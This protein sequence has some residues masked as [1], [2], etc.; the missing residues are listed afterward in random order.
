TPHGGS[1]HY[2][3]ST[4]KGAF[5]SR[6]ERALMNHTE[7]FLFESAFARNTYQR[8]IGTP[9]ALVRCVFNGV[10]AKE[11][12]PLSITEDATGVHYVGEFRNIKGAD[13]L[14]D[15]IARLRSMG[16][17][18][19]LTLAG[20]GEEMPALQAQSERLN[21]KSAVR[22]IGHVPARTGFSKGRV[23]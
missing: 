13:I 2:A 23:L 19:T 14:I 21:L 8:T 22:F 7:L 3:L 11:F 17:S 10:A 15:A 16:R 6:L 5:Y 4:A 9:K 1:L 18:A 12:D 20:D